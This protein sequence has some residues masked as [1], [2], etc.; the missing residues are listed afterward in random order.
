MRERRKLPIIAGLEA[1]QGENSGLRDVGYFEGRIMKI[2]DADGGLGPLENR[3]GIHQNMRKS[4]PKTAQNLSRRRQRQVS[5]S[6]TVRK[7]PILPR[8]SSGGEN[9]PE[10]PDCLVERMRFEMMALRLWKAL[11]TPVAR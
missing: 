2:V 8:Y 4:G 1:F 3:A 10:I 11:F 9:C 7:P 6:E 5:V